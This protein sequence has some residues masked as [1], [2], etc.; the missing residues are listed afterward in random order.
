MLPVLFLTLATAAT[1]VA[2]A[3]CTLLPVDR[4]GKTGYVDTTGR[5]AIPAR[6]DRGGTFNE[7]LTAVSVG[8]KMG[9]I[10]CAGGW[11]I[12]PRFDWAQHCQDGW[13]R[14][15]EKYGDFG[16]Y[17][18]K[19]SRFPLRVLDVP[20]MPA[21]GMVV[22]IGSLHRYG[23]MDME[24]GH[25]VGP[26]FQ[27]AKPAFSE[28]LLGA[29]E[30]EDHC[31][32][33]DRTGSWVIAPT[34]CCV[35]DFHEGLARVITAKNEALYIDHAGRPA[36]ATPLTH[37][38]DFRDGIAPA[39]ADDTHWGVLDRSGAF[40][41]APQ[42]EFIGD[43]RDGRMLFM[44]GKRWGVI[45]YTGKIV[46]DAMFDRA[47]LLP[48]GIVDV[49]FGAGYYDR[50]GHAIEA[51]RSLDAFR[52]ISRLALVAQN[53]HA[54]C[55]A[56][57]VDVRAG[58]TA[59]ITSNCPSTANRAATNKPDPL[60]ETGPF[61]STDAGQVFAVL[62]KFA[63]DNDLAHYDDR[64]TSYGIDIEYDVVEIETG[65][66]TRSLSVAYGIAPSLQMMDWALRQA[67]REIAWSRAAK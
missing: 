37:G 60:Q 58:G 32:F 52:D 51:I 39:G 36:F 13:C 21:E 8:K 12:A 4:N 16:L 41:V 45:D 49:H 54:V 63:A 48:G 34:Y 31:G 11:V 17:D 25:V 26:R 66:G 7:G 61:V 9:F 44:H 35:S 10:D 3:D 65:A 55:G 29:C 15:G 24:T 56:F 22:G 27:S 46:L 59:T 19:G 14:A 38:Q 6:F 33:V 47:E 2:P 43:H 40:V 23:F 62:A 18:R 5:L 20:F 28:G 67:V 42:F 53:G 64:H 1:D 57:R 30:T 50:D